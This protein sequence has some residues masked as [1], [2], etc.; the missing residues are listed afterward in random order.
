MLTRCRPELVCFYYARAVNTTGG[1]DLSNE[2]GVYL[3]EPLAVDEGPRSGSGLRLVSP[4]PTRGRLQIVYATTA[5]A[6][7]R[8]GVFDI[9]GRE[10][11]TV[12]DEPQAAGEHR[13]AWGGANLRPASIYFLRLY[14]DGKPIGGRRL[15]M[16][17]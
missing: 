2:A 6:R 11:A 1:S 7:V 16:L 13:V 12:V 3:S 5:T 15:A 8:I 9:A 17:R 14:V 10:V 4:N